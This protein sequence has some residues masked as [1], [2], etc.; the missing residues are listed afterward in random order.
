M[1]TN[2]AQANINPPP[3]PP[4]KMVCTGVLGT[5]NV[6]YFFDSNSETSGLAPGDQYICSGA[7]ILP[8]EKGC[9]P[10]QGKSLKEMLAV[11]SIG[12]ECSI[13]GW[14]RNLSHGLY[15]WSRIDWVSPKLK[16]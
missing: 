9:W 3:G 8:R 7:S 10:L 6:I 14:I 12:K 11:C 4:F 13:A 16:D 5:N 2:V 15:C 1:A